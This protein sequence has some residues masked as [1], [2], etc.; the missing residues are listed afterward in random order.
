MW[1]PATVIIKFLIVLPF[2]EKNS[3]LLSPRNIAAPVIAG[4]VSAAGYYVAEGILFGSFAAPAA[5]LAGSLIQS[6]GSAALFYVAALIM[7]RS[8]VT[9]QIRR[10][11][12]F[13]KA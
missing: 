8:H 1:M 5:S 12:G 3:R 6:G 7:E 11:M 9:I 13:E 10:L 4:V 2:T